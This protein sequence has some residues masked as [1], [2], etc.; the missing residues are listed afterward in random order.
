[1]IRTY[2]VTGAVS[3]RSV[4]ASARRRLDR[5]GTILLSSAYYPLSI[6]SAMHTLF[7]MFSLIF[8]QRLVRFGLCSKQA[9]VW[10]FGCQFSTSNRTTHTSTEMGIRHADRE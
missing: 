7:Q 2:R 1:M 3:M 5:C 10:L 4:S 9:A 6:C 8:V